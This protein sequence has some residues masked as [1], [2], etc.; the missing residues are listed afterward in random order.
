LAGLGHDNIIKL[1]SD[2]EFMQNLICPTSLLAISIL[3]WKK[4]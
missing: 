2:N 3:I 4:K 1:I